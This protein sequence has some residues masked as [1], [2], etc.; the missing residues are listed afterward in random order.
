MRTVKEAFGGGFDEGAGGV[1]ETGVV[2]GREVN[3]VDVFW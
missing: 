2:I 1:K 3:L